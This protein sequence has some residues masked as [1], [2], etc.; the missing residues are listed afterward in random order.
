MVF[1][2]LSNADI[3]TEVPQIP[4]CRGIIL[5]KDVTQWRDSDFKAGNKLQVELHTPNKLGNIID[6]YRQWPVLQ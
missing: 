2:I 1:C 5:T 3:A 6:D 4:N